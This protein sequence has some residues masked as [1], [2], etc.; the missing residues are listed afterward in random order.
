MDKAMR[1]TRNE[2]F[3]D[4]RG[5]KGCR[6]GCEGKE[7][8]APARRKGRNRRSVETTTWTVP[9]LPEWTPAAPWEDTRTLVVESAASTLAA[10]VAVAVDERP[11]GSVVPSLV[12]IKPSEL[13][14]RGIFARENIVRGTP[15]GKYPGR[16]RTQRQMV[17][18]C[19]AVPWAKDYVYQTEEGYF[20]DPTDKEGKLSNK[21]GPGLPWPFPV[22]IEMALA[23]EPPP[24]SGGANVEFEEKG[25]DV[26]LVCTRDVAAG[27]ELYLDYGTRYSRSGYG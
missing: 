24:G 23:N 1:A 27:E 13:H 10:F 18:K 16:R 12:E 15:L 26:I 8:W 25:S 17:E 22:P 9:S 2:G 4:G 14:G 6:R 5:R 11:R 20:L 3:G 21:P 19:G 7:N